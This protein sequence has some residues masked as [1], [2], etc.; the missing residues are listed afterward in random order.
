MC[1]VSASSVPADEATAIGITNGSVNMS[2]TGTFKYDEPISCTI[3]T[4]D[5]V[6]TAAGA[7]DGSKIIKVYAKSADGVW[8]N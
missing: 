6:A 1:C 5:L 4:A 2:A 8:S 7:G 3:K